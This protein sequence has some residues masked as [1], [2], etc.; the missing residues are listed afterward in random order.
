MFLA[1]VGSSKKGAMA[2]TDY[3]LCLLRLLLLHIPP[4]TFVFSLPPTPVLISPPDSHPNPTSKPTFLL[5]KYDERRGISNHAVPVRQRSREGPSAP[6]FHAA[7][8]TTL[9]A[10]LPCVLA[11]SLPLLSQ[12]PNC[13][14]SLPGKIGKSS[15]SAP[16]RM[17]IPLDIP[18]DSGVRVNACLCVCVSVHVRERDACCCFKSFYHRPICPPIEP[19][20]CSHLARLAQRATHTHTT[21][22]VTNTHKHGDNQLPPC[23][24]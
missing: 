19:N 10:H 6:A 13:F 22:K 11:V 7:K 12:P 14:L 9:E 24:L 5:K 1:P 8:T 18:I 2:L 23:V 20:R 3:S 15:Y 17:G 21:H 16:I 4:I